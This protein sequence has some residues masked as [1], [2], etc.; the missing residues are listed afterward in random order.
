LRSRL[1]IVDVRWRVFG[2]DLEG[3]RNRQPFALNN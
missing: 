1:P 2:R 3:D